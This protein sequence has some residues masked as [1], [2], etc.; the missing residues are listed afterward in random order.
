MQFTPTY[1]EKYAWIMQIITQ[2]FVHLFSLPT[3]NIDWLLIYLV[4]NTFI[5]IAKILQIF[6]NF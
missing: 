2:L 6:N 1:L 3:N 5:Q 4:P